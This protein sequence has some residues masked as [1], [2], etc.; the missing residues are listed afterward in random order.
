M[1]F[2]LAMDTESPIVCVLVIHASQ[3]AQQGRG[4]F[5]VMSVDSTAVVWNGVR[6]ARRQLDEGLHTDKFTRCGQGIRP[7]RLII[8]DIVQPVQGSGLL[9]GVNLAP[10]SGRHGAN[11]IRD[12]GQV[13]GTCCLH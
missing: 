9:D 7:H 11:L 3:N 2:Q 8:Q 13:R 12:G 1:D 10:N 4:V 5:V 6:S